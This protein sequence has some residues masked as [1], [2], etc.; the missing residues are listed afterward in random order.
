MKKKGGWTTE[1]RLKQSQMIQNWKPWEQ[2]TGAK[3][4]EGKVA[5]S[6]NAFKG[7]VWAELRLLRRETN[8]L[9]KEQKELLEKIKM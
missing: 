7:G 4:V 5:S 3:T 8:A 6:Q 2:S 1:R 9:L